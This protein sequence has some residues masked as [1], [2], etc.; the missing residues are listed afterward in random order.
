[1]GIVKKNRRFL[2]NS[3]GLV[4]S[5]S[6]LR[7]LTHLGNERFGSQEIVSYILRTRFHYKCIFTICKEPFEDDTCY[8]RRYTRRIPTEYRRFR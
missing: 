6:V 4:Y 8:P 5:N 1:M 7:V 3:D 2:Y